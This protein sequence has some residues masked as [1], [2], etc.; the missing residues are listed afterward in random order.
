MVRTAHRDVKDRLRQAILSRA[1]PPGTRL[2]QAE[3]A[4]HL[5][6][7]VTP[8]REALR[9]LEGLGL[10]D[11]DAFRGATVHQ[12]SVEELEEIYELRRFLVPLAI[13]ERVR[14]ITTVELA[15][16][17]AIAAGMTAEISDARWVEDNRRL[18]HLLDGVAERPHLRTILQRLSDVSALYVDISVHTDP[19]RRSRARK[20]HDELVRAYRARDAA[21]VT[22][23]TLRHLDDT[24]RVATRA[25]LE[26]EQ[27]KTG[28]A[29]A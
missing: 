8:I 22:K 28:Q 14:T 9:E 18:H 4:T 7:S 19:E 16:A 1:L 15:E 24:A 17:E 5:S 26:S 2:I 25:L 3:L 27:G 23:I 29:G 6:V 21:A 12:V 10:V 11:F 20:D 13:R